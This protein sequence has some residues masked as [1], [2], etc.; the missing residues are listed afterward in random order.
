L[1]AGG[2][3]RAFGSLSGVTQGVKWRLLTYVMVS[4]GFRKLPSNGEMA[5][6]F[7]FP[8]NR[9]EVS[10]SESKPSEVSRD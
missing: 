4:V 3:H 1:R 9:W 7:Q 5:I 8:H 10:K 6:A 2:A